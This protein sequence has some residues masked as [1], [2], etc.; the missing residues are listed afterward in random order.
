MLQIEV[1][2]LVDVFHQ[3]RIG[4]CYRNRNGRKTHA[5]DPLAFKWIRIVFRRWQDRVPYD[6]VY[7]AALTKRKSPLAKE[8]RAE[9]KLNL[10]AQ[11]FRGARQDASELRHKVDLLL[12][13][14]ASQRDVATRLAAI[15]RITVALKSAPSSLR[16]FHLRQNRAC[17]G[18]LGPHAV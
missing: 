9:S 8:F 1:I 17:P 10:L 13:R 18:G 14:M 16:G 3:R 7:L 15:C 5:F 4:R 11:Q 12:E 6:A 2:F